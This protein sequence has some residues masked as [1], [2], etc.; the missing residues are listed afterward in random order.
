MPSG[1]PL[2]ITFVTG[3][4]NKLEEV[5]SILSGLEGIR[6][7]SKNVD[8]PE[9]QGEPQDIVREKC[10]LAAN[11]IQGPVMVE[12][13]CLCFNAL[14]GLPGPYIKWFL[15]K[16]GHDGLNRLLVGFDD[17]SAFALCTFAFCLGADKEP[18]I[19]SGK[20]DGI[21][22]SP[23]GPKNFGWDPIFQPLGFELTYAEMDKAV[24]NQISHRYKALHELQEYLIKQVVSK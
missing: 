19:L 15:Q 9:L 16:L 6:I 18:V 2:T 17:K 8:L 14:Q 24:K 23:R 13:T 1:K 3:N 21:I 10:K 7:E 22:V 12:D 5:R 4:R 20:T 11:A